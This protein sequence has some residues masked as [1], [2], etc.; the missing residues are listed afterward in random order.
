MCLVAVIEA[1]AVVAVF[2]VLSPG[3]LF[4]VRAYG[5]AS[6]AAICGQLYST[7]VVM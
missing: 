3:T 5:S 2:N 7:V 4:N 6:V 1:A